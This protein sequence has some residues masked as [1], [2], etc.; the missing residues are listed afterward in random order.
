M[1]YEAPERKGE[2]DIVETLSR[3]DNS[4]EERIG[5][6]LSA[7]YYGKSLEFSGDTLIGEFSR[8]KYSERRSL[9]NLFETFYGMC[10]TS[11]RVDDSIA[12]L[13]AYRREVPE[14]APEID[15]TLEALSEYKATLKNV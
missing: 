4:P 3:T 11:Y 15:A 7:L 10:R 6:V 2:E 9:K 5:A 8:A 14:Y 12:L 13:E 1:R